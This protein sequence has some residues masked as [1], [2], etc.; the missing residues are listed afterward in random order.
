MW[1][2]WLMALPF[3]MLHW[4]WLLWGDAF[5]LWVLHK[6][7]V[8]VLNHLPKDGRKRSY[9]MKWNDPRLR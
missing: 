6:R 1:R 5:K 3:F 8:W 7:Q 4:A 2:I 9:P